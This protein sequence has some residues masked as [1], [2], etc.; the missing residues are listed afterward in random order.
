MSTS[1]P[2]G[3]PRDPH[4]TLG[5]PPGTPFDEV[6]LVYRRLVRELHPDV[7]PDAR[8]R[9]DAV[10]AAFEVLRAQNASARKAPPP[11][12]GDEESP[13]ARLQRLG[14][15]ADAT[16]SGTSIG[17]SWPD[18]SAAASLDDSATLSAPRSPSGTPGTT[19]APQ[20]HRTAA[21]E[22]LQAPGHVEPRDGP[23]DEQAPTAVPVLK[24][25][26]VPGRDSL[27]VQPRAQMFYALLDLKLSDAVQVSQQPLNMSL[28]LDHSSSM[29]RNDKLQRLKEAV[30]RI[31]DMMNPRDYLSIVT[32]GDRASVL[33]PSAPLGNKRAARQAL[34]AIRCRGGTEISTGIRAGLQE[35]RGHS[36]ALI[37]QMIL[38]TDGQ[39]YGDEDICLT[40]ATQ[41]GEQ[42]VQIT[43]L[44][45]GDDWNSALLDELAARTGGYTDYV[46]S[47]EQLASVFEEHLHIIQRTAL[48]NLRMVIATSSS[49]RLLRATWVAPGIK[50][51]PVPTET[52]TGHTLTLDLGRMS[53]DRDYRLLLELVV[54][55]RGEGSV[56]VATIQF[57]YDVPG[58]SRENESITHQLFGTFVKRWDV[59][60]PVHLRV[61]D[62]LRKITAHRLQEQAMQ[63][64]QEGQ[65]Q[66]GTANLRTAA[67]HLEAAGCA[68]LADL[69]RMEAERV[70]RQGQAQAGSMKRIIYGTRKLG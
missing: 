32:F 33:L 36:S 14:L 41:A 7:N 42:Q 10:Q 44:G 69:A 23:V 24:V 58:M 2:E 30:S 61:H 20:S 9:F 67:K 64:I 25:H 52:P 70:E 28:V 22:D 48:R 16:P 46:Q 63:A 8:G 62:A 60:P 26:V 49:S 55:S 68:E 37:S 15:H 66:K 51:L 35:L 12:I 43:A 3:D 1:I 34:D 21:P 47:A 31:V 29:Q 45:L 4:A 57:M 18:T 65:T 54:A 13:A 27:L 11:L 19:G 56:D 39:T 50:P 53:N 40:L 17:A 59:D 5:V 6:K 38:L